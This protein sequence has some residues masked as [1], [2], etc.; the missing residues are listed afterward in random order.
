MCALPF[1]NKKTTST[2]KLFSQPHR[3]GERRCLCLSAQ[4]TQSTHEQRNVFGN[5]IGATTHTMKIL[6]LFSCKRST[7]F[8]R[9][10]QCNNFTIHTQ[11]LQLKNII[12]AVNAPNAKARYQPFLKNSTCNF[13]R[14]ATQFQKL[15]AKLANE[16]L[17]LF[18]FCKLLNAALGCDIIKKHQTQKVVQ[19]K[20]RNAFVAPQR[21]NA[22]IS[23]SCI[24]LGTLRSL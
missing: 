11:H 4:L 14:N 19:S 16:N 24:F 20:K 13:L 10:N 8:K 22:V 21:K 7:V 15:A 23:M 1:V 17:L 6:Y 12:R 9:T 5:K 3:S 2:G 18:I